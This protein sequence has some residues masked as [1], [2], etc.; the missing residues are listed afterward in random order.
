MDLLLLR[1]YVAAQGHFMSSRARS[2]RGQAT[3]EYVLVLL[4]V[5][6]IAI[7]VGAWAARSGKVGDLLDKVFDNLADQVE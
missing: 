6:A 5:A 2:Q 3:T 1:A 4:G 7:A